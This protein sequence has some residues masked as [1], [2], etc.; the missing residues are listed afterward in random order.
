MFYFQICVAF[1]F[2]NDTL[3]VSFVAGVAV[4]VALIPLNARISVLAKRAQAEQM[5][6]KDER[7]K[8]MN[9]I[10][11]GIKV[12]LHNCLYGCVASYLCSLFVNVFMH[13][14]YDN[15]FQYF[16]NFKFLTVY[17][18]SNT[19]VL[20]V[21]AGF[22]IIILCL[23]DNSLSYVCRFLFHFCDGMWKNVSPLFMTIFF[24][25]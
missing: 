19:H 4:I 23:F 20:F 10:L 3:G 5:R 22:F 11:S 18:F 21:T 9:E 1:Y 25:C 13:L 7:L 17:Y 6:V 24:I 14:I 2:L 12:W 15:D 16:R 8:I